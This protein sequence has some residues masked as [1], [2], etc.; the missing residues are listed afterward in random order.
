MEIGAFLDLMG[1]IGSLTGYPVIRLAVVK[2]D[3]LSSVADRNILLMGT[4]STLGPAADLLKNSPYRVNGSRLTVE[5]PTAS[6]ASGACSAIAG[7]RP[8]A[9]RD[10]RS[11]RPPATTRRPWSAR[12]AR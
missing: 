10:R 11:T 9:R 4:I 5:L 1:Q 12:R 7:R 6:T 2:P 8:A 3:G